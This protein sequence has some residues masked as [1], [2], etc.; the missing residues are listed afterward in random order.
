MTAAIERRKRQSRAGMS[1]NMLMSSWTKWINLSL[2]T[3]TTTSSLLPSSFPLLDADR[4]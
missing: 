2:G 1:Y 4:A 3:Y